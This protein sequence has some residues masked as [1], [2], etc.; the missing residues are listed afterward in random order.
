MNPGR[1]GAGEMIRVKTFTS[2]LKIFHTRNELLELDQAVN[3][4]VASRGIRKLISVGDA[5]TTGKGNSIGIIRVIAYEEPGE[6][7]REKVFGKMEEK[8]ERWGGEIE[9]L[10][11]RADKVGADARAKFREQMADLRARQENA[12]RKLEEMK[13][14]GGEAWE[15]LRAGADAALDDLRK[16]VERAARKRK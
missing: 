5:V 15:E 13:K 8:L 9:K 7:T 6:G 10:R 16:A 2:Q 4:F 1:K 3:D 14:S 12:L 11:A